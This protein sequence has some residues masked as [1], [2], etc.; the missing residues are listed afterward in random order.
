MRMMMNILG[1]AQRSRKS[2]KFE[3]L[4]KI[5]TMNVPSNT[6]IFLITI[7]FYNVRLAVA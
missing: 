2:T 1:I 7:R 5:P 3:F 4:R 6:K